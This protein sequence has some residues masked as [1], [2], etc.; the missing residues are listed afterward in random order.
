[1]IPSAALIAS[2]Q[3]TFEQVKKLILPPELI[4]TES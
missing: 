2:L 1:M 4:L 3:L